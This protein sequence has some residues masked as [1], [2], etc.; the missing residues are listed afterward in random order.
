MAPPARLNRTRGTAWARARRPTISDDRVM[1]YTWY[2]RATTVT[3]RPMVETICPI[4]RR[5][6]S[7]ESR[8][9][10]VSRAR[11]RRAAVARRGGRAVSMETRQYGRVAS[12][13]LVDEGALERWLGDQ[14]PG[15]GRPLEVERITTGHS[16]EVFEV[17]RAGHR[18][19]LR[20]PPRVPLSPTAHDMM[21]EFR[22][23]SAL[24]GTGVPHPRPLVA[25]A[26]A[27]LLAAPWSMMEPVDALVLL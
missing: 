21:R 18:W 5:R 8:S 7:R 15:A 2:G 24:E 23:L 12:D 20:R 19:I 10:L 26:D 11:P 9:G 13:G 25:C 3:W 22:V 14:L 27:A 4:Q 1:T 17:R 6:K 16:N